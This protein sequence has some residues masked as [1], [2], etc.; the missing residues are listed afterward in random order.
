M[1]TAMIAGMSILGLFDI[2]INVFRIACGL[3]LLNTG[4]NMMN[5]TQQVVVQSG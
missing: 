3:L 4:I 2:S 5:S 1:I